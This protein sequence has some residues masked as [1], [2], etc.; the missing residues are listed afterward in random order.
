MWGVF[1]HKNRGRLLSKKNAAHFSLTSGAGRRN[2]RAGPAVVA[3]R[4][5]LVFTGR[6]PVAIVPLGAVETLRG[7]RVVHVRP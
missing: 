1:V 7:T 2:I 5:F 4:A 3:N 6:A